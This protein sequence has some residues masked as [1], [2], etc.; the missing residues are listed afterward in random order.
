M[1]TSCKL[2]Q[3]W[4]AIT[5]MKEKAFTKFL[6]VNSLNSFSLNSFTLNK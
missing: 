1:G 2:R 3:Q 5:I 4:K 6:N